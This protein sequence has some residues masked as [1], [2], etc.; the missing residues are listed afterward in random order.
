MRRR[1]GWI[2]LCAAALLGAGWMLSIFFV[3]TMGVGP[4]P[5]AQTLQIANGSFVLYFSESA[6]ASA[7]PAAFHRSQRPGQASWLPHSGTVPLGGP[8]I[9]WW[10]IPLWI[11]PSVALLPAAWCFRSRKSPAACAGCGYLRAGLAP[12]AVCPECGRVPGA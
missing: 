2:L 12:G 4:H 6:P 5:G 8:A 7:A 11:P 9:R 10:S 1:V 3:A